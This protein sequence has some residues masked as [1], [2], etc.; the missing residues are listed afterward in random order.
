MKTIIAEGTGVHFSVFVMNYGNAAETFN[1]T[2]YINATLLETQSGVAIPSKGYAIVNFTWDTDLFERGSYA[3]GAEVTAVTGETDTNDNRLVCVVALSVVG[4]VDNNGIV[5]MLDV[6]NVALHFG[7]IV[8]QAHY[9]SNYD[10][11]D[12][13]I[14]NMLDLYTTAV[15]YGQ[16]GTKQVQ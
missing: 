7:A 6:Y 9:V 14:I 15:H 13:G 1:V 16:T 4:D 8:G 3:I 12:N 11:D 10:I 5:N 2:T